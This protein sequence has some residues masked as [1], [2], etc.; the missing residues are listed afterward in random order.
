MN[1]NEFR[2]QKLADYEA[3]HSKPDHPPLLVGGWVYY[4]DGAAREKN[5]W[6]GAWCEPDPDPLSRAKTILFYHEK[7]LEFAVTEFQ[8]LKSSLKAQA[9]SEYLGR[10]CPPNSLVQRE[11]MRKLK[12]MK[13]SI[14]VLQRRF[15]KAEQEL[16]EIED[17]HPS[18]RRH[19]QRRDAEHRQTAE[20]FVAEI[21]DIEI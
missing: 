12:D 9:K 16:K 4:P 17:N 2:R 1:D 20:E 14:E 15:E 18:S 19:Q 3:R 13:S 7:R 11:G 5:P 8:Y 21:N 10:P 6:A